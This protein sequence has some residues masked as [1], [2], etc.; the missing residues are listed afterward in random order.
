MAT[1]SDVQ[2]AVVGA[3]LAGLTAA[4][5]L[6]QAGVDVGLYEANPERVGGRCWTA[7]GYFADGIHGEHG[8]ERLDTD[9]VEL[10]ALAAELGLEINDLE[11]DDSAA[12]SLF[13]TNSDLSVEEIQKGVRAVVAADLERRGLKPA[14]GRLTNATVLPARAELDSMSLQDWIIE[15]VEG[16]IEGPVGR[17]LME[18][19]RLETGYEADQISAHILLEGG[20]LLLGVP[21]SREGSGDMRYQVRGGNDRIVE[22]LRTRLPDDVLTL[23]ARLTSIARTGQ[24]Y[25]LEFASGLTV[26]ARTV[27][28][29]LPFP[30][31]RKVDLSESGFSGEKRAA[32]EEYGLG[33]VSKM[34]MQFN[35]Q[36]SDFPEWNGVIV[37]DDPRWMVVPTSGGQQGDSMLLTAFIFGDRARNLGNGVPH[38]PAPEAVLTAVLD[39]IDGQVPG[40]REAFNGRAWLNCWSDSEYA[41]GA[42]SVFKP[43]QTTRFGRVAGAPDGAAFFAGEHTSLRHRSTFNGAVE[44]GQRAAQ[45]AINFLA[46]AHDRAAVTRK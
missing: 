15:S 3:G 32:I 30:T 40:L 24:G 11:D 18:E 10:Y 21:Q 6:Q 31:L 26:Q 4:Y 17:E 34:I 7:R 45:E 8:G 29:A 35:C 38:A 27:V 23:G 5:G 43:G 36:L 41:G 20:E 39:I 25:W 28:L 1:K 22:E 42:W 14:D 44:S 13:P 46:S 2:V 16:G 19:M 12:I 37:S 33:A 9:Y